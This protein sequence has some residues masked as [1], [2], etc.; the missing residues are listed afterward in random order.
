MMIFKRI[1]FFFF[2]YMGAMYFS[3]TLVILW[4]SK[5][6]F[7]FSNIVFYYLISYVVALVGIFTLRKIK[8]ELKPTILLGVLASALSVALIINI[9]S[10]YQLYLSAIV[11]GLNI[12]FFWIP[13]NVMYFKFS[14]EE[15]RGLNSGIYFLVTPII[16]ITLQPLAGLIAEKF[17]F[18]TMFL[19]GLS[20]YIIPIFLIRFLPDF[21]MNLKVKNELKRWKFNWS[22]F[23]QGFTARINWSLVPIFTLFF[24]STP[25]AFGSFFGYLAIF[26]ATASLINASISDRMKSRKLFFYLFTSLAV[27][28]LFPLAFVQ[29]IFYWGIFA[30]VTSLCICLANPFWLAFNLD[31]YHEVGAEKAMILREIYL[32]LGYITALLVAF[33]VFYFTSSVKISLITVSIIAIC[34]PVVSYFQRVYRDI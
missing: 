26:A 31:Y 15:R 14:S 25:K 28:S 22:T 8:M 21:E 23:F 3:Q 10:I 2:T 34:L 24:I 11:T 5:N 4:L 16:S 20:L 19:V 9:S 32:N 17:G 13:Y 29:N 7:G 1:Y 6:G 27:I 33:I 12:I 30:G 18:Q